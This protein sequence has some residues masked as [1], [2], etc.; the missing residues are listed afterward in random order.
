MVARLDQIKDHLTAIRGL[1]AA[2]PFHPD[3][4]LELA[5]DGPLRDE[6]E[7]E[8]ARLEL[9]A[10]VRFLG[11]QPVD[12][13]LE[14]WDIYL[15]STT[16]GEGMGTAVAEAMLAGLPC[17]VT[18]LPVMREVCGPEGAV[19]ASPGDPEM[20]AH[21]LVRLARDRAWRATLGRAAQ[22]RARRLFGRQHTAAAYQRILF[23][24]G[25]DA[26]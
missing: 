11:F 26:A 25:K 19:Y 22:D 16:P 14:E 12:R 17:L 21:G 15:H 18:D 20:L 7:Q 4:V 1:A 13:L 9:G 5:G 8:A 6:L 23:P 2:T 3:M 24:A 10:R